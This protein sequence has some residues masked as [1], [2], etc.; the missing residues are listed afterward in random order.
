[1]LQVNVHI[2]NWRV[3]EHTCT[4]ETGSSTNYTDS[5]SLPLPVSPATSLTRLS[6]WVEKMEKRSTREDGVYH[7]DGLT[8]SQDDPRD[9]PTHVDLGLVQVLPVLGQSFFRMS[10]SNGKKFVFRLTEQ[11][12]NWQRLTSMSTTP[13]SVSF[14]TLNDVIASS[15]G[16]YPTHTH[17]HQWK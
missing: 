6:G 4:T 14:S 3:F 8:T 7:T 9:G 1:M 10:W 17:T 16:L 2:C 11:V 13:C 5:A 12:L 15:I